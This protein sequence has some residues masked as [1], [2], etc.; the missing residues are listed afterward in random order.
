MADRE[1]L[2]AQAALATRYGREDSDRIDRQ[3]FLC[4]LPTKPKCCSPEA[5]EVAWQF[6][7]DRL[8]ERG[9]VGPKRSEQSRRGVGGGIQRSKADCL[10][11]CDKGPIAVVWPDGVFYHSCDPP[12]L[13]RIIEEH[14]IGGTPVEDYRLYPATKGQAAA[15]RP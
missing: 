11:I 9:L 12:V 8:K 13:D 14:L 2:S 6:L 1:L 3:I 4:A 5:G 7:K 10:Q 15:R